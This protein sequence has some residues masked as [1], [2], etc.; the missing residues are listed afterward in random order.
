MMNPN[1]INIEYVNKQNEFMPFEITN[2]DYL[3]PISDPRNNDFY[4]TVKSLDC[5]MIYWYNFQEFPNITSIHHEVKN[6]ADV[7]PPF[8]YHHHLYTCKTEAA[9][10][11]PLLRGSSH[12]NTLPSS[13]TYLPEAAPPMKKL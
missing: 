10:W 13:V 1:E 4:F 11:P 8:P 3:Y 2:P 7:P 12:S 5:E 9:N 6:K